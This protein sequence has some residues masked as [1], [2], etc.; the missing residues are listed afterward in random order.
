MEASSKLEKLLLEKDL[1]PSL[2]RIA[3]NVLQGKRISEDDGLYL[4]EHAPL[5]YLGVLANH[6]REQKHGNR[7]YF[8]RNFHIEP[9]NVCLYTC[10]FCSYSRLIKKRDEG[11]EYSLEDIMNIVRSYDGQPV[12]EVHI[13]GG[14]LPQYDVK[15]YTELFR[16]IKSHRPDLH[17]KALTPVEYHYIFKKDKISYEEG[18]RLMK[19]AGLDSMPGGGAEIFHPEIRDQIAGGK[20]S[21]EQ[22][23]RI[24]EIWHEL[25]MRS[26]ATM[27]YGHIESFYHRV[28]HLEQLRQLQDKTGGFQTF[29]PLKFRNKDNQ[30][31]HVAESTVV[32]D[33]RNYAISRIYLDNFDHIK[34]YWPMIGRQ[35]AQMSLAFGVNDIDG[36]IDDTTKIYSMAGSEEQAPAMSTRELVNLIRQVGRQPI[37][38]DTLYG[39]MEDYTDHVWEEDTQ[40]KGYLS[41]PVV[42]N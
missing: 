26:N 9:T 36:T 18:M 32:E 42:Q 37:E 12:T 15:F 13:V 2:H 39:V 4:F 16:Q 40:F 30:M 38:R 29:I 33:L 11:W 31:S 35:I 14:V 8:N 34:A 1:N 20:C 27:L 28:H 10:T 6:V 5:A 24:H 41:L 22:W 25:G 17:V 7:T 19:E 3:A 23:L 21:G